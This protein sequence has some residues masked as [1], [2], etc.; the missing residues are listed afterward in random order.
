MEIV[1]H[2]ALIII[3]AGAVIF[4]VWL[5]LKK[6]QEKEVKHLQIELKKER[7]KFFLPNRVEAYQRSVLLM[8]R[9][10]PLS[11]VMRLHNPGLPAKALQ[12]DLLK[13]IREE[14]DHN[15]AQQIFVSPQAWQMVRT[16]K[17]ETVKIINLA[18]NQ[19]GPA[20]SGMEISAKIF[21]ICA[22]IGTLPTDITIDYLKK[23]LQELF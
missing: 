6:Q 2:L 11:I 13:A 9:I 21:E 14:Y 22:E 15:V 8:E 20:A 12:A 5:F 23:E 4:T 17:E 1:L 18:G 3:P 16:T 7:Q 10:S 19:M